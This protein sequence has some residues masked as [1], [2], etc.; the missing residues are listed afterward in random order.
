MYMYTLCPLL[1]CLLNA[2]NE[3]AEANSEIVTDWENSYI[4]VYSDCQ[5]IPFI[6]FKCVKSLSNVNLN[7]LGLMGNA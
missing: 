1:Y 6:Y 3:T 2:D 7:K 5:A 4:P